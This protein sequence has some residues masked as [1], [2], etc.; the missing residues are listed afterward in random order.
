MAASPGGH[1]RRSTVEEIVPH[2][3]TGVSP[4]LRPG[5]PDR[6]WLPA[7]SVAGLRGSV[8]GKPRNFASTE[9]QQKRRHEGGAFD[10]FRERT[11]LLRE[12]SEP[13]ANLGPDL[14]SYCLLHGLLL[15][16]ELLHQPSSLNQI[17]ALSAS[18]LCGD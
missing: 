16:F 7:T 9:A 5:R 10:S 3:D 8:R 18:Q 17:V 13:A 1:H 11:R 12:Y 4:N 14:D 6:A 2:P 15:G